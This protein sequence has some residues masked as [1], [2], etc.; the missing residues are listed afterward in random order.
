V[1]NLIPHGKLLSRWSDRRGAEG[2]GGQEAPGRS[3]GWLHHYQY[4][5][6]GPLFAGPAGMTMLRAHGCTALRP[7]AVSAHHTNK[8]DGEDDEGCPGPQ[9]MTAIGPLGRTAR[10]SDA[11]IK[12]WPNAFD[13][14][15][16]GL[17]EVLCDCASEHGFDVLVIGLH[18]HGGLVSR[19]IGHIA[20]A[21]VRSC[22]TAVLLVSAR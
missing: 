17:A 13:V 10:R 5:P 14:E 19:K 22:S 6:P 4:A 18:G 11:S 20:E 8:P 1:D 16:R 12:A 9:E 21:V 2:T 7:P 15:R 3:A